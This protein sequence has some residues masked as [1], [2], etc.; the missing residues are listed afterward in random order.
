MTI[1]VCDAYGSLPSVTEKAVLFRVWQ[2]V[3]E[4]DRAAEH[5]LGFIR[6]NRLDLLDGQL[7]EIGFDLE[8]E[9]GTAMEEDMG[10]LLE[11]QGD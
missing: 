3:V 8:G 1:A 5:E 6:H 9:L 2:M 7:L 4:I 10:R 11:V